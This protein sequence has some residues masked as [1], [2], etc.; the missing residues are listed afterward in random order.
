MLAI[1]WA[2]VKEVTAGEDGKKVDDAQ[3]AARK[4]ERAPRIRFEA[5]EDIELS[6]SH[7]TLAD[8]HLGSHHVQAFFADIDDFACLSVCRLSNRQPWI[9]EEV[10]VEQVLAKVEIEDIRRVCETMGIEWNRT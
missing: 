6:D 4:A 3:D 1:Q 9:N 5:E 10:V 2:T 7:H 8:V